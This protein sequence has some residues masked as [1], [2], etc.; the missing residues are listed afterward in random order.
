MQ[1]QSGV[2]KGAQQAHPD[3]DERSQQGFHAGRA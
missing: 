1:G 2:G 3:P